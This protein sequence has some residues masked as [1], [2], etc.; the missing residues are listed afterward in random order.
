MSRTRDELFELV[1]G[2]SAAQCGRVL[3]LM[4]VLCPRNG[5]TR[6]DAILSATFGRDS[7]CQIHWLDLFIRAVD[8][9][10]AHH[11]DDFSEWDVSTLDMEVLESGYDWSAEHTEILD[12]YI[13]Q[14]HGNSEKLPKFL[15]YSFLKD[16][17]C[18]Q[19]SSRDED[20]KFSFPDGFLW[21]SANQLRAFV[22]EPVATS[23]GDSN[24][25]DSARLQLL[26]L[27][28]QKKQQQ[29]DDMPGQVIHKL[30]QDI[31]E[32]K[33]G[34]TGDKSVAV[35]RRTMAFPVDP[36][37]FF[38]Y[39]YDLD[40]NGA[41]HVLCDSERP[42]SRELLAALYFDSTMSSAVVNKIERRNL[43]DGDYF[44]SARQLSDAKKQNLGDPSSK[45]HQDFERLRIRQQ[46]QIK[47]SQP[48]LKIINH[49]SRAFNPLG[50]LL[51]R[52]RP[53][54]DD[55]DWGEDGDVD[56]IEIGGEL[57][58]R[59]DHV[60]PRDVQRS[61]REVSDHLVKTLHAC[62]DALHLV[63]MECSE[64]ERQRDDLYLDGVTGGSG[65]SVQRPHADPT[66]LEKDTSKLDQ[67]AHDERLRRKEL[68]GSRSRSS[69]RGVS[70][71][72]SRTRTPP[73]S[74][75]KPTK[76]ERD[77]QSK[78]DKAAAAAKKSAVGPAPAPSPSPSPSG[79]AAGTGPKNGGGAKKKK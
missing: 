7:R 72:S 12:T 5:P 29:L 65:L 21:P 47:N 41:R 69:T 79:G 58:S 26:E 10:G 57:F 13:D 24:E 22:G 70:P 63:G 71:G 3:D 36:Q 25:S 33:F 46:S 61:L 34:V 6:R 1:S 19:P 28:L 4:G 11:S 59:L 2:Y 27:Q 17:D 76:A 23:S 49:T 43:M 66:R 20:P 15:P 62:S 67:M 16:L 42:L 53:R 32:N 31:S 54:R 38:L 39:G 8:A 35:L 48:L 64:L 40:E 37:C 52:M 68:A 14:I 78:K 60:L 55:A 50:V 9:F 75:T 74:R 56:E 18:L 45:L 77:A 30:R 44:I 51:E 73:P